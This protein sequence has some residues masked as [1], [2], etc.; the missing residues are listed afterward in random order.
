LIE[1]SEVA[2]LIENSAVILAGGLGSRLRTVLSDRP[3]VLAPV[4]GRHFLSYLLDQ[5][6][7]AGFQDV[8]LCTGYL[9][10]QVREVF[11]S[12]FRRLELQYSEE[13]E[14]RGT[15]GALR[16]ALRLLHGDSVLVLNGDSYCQTDLAAFFKWHQEKHSDASLVL[17]HVPDVS[18]FGSVEFDG[19]HRIQRFVEKSK[20]GSGWINA[21]IYAIS[22]NLIADIPDQAQVSLEH[23]CFPAW[24]E[25]G[26]FAYPAATDNAGRFL[27]IGTP[28]T[29]QAAQEFFAPAFS[30]LNSRGPR[31]ALLDRDG[32]LIVERNY[33]RNPS[34][35]ELF[36]G[37][38]D[39]LRKLR[40]LGLRLV[41][42]S[43]QS[44]IARGFFDEQKLCQIH[45]RLRALLG[46]ADV[47]LDAIYYCPHLPEQDCA[48]R[49]PQP[50][51]VERAAR[52]LG[53]D[54]HDSFVVGDKACDMELGTRVGATTVLVRTGYGQETL[55]AGVSADYTVQDL[56]E[57]AAEIARHVNLD[58][59]ATVR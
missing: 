11:G 13:S 23:D 1:S 25:I 36:P 44:G 40:S 4:A 51:M 19:D 6:A 56:S 22:K 33:L 20:S 17:A 59:K 37:A 45:E 12:R 49:K 43:N 35:V 38:P 50:G 48:C 34:E 18:R 10:E 8:V 53:L 31:C 2:E 5:L 30:R 28:A 15:G 41:L 54:P 26:M 14:P 52:D 16:N 24:T 47:A 29:L 46:D 27:D 58:A 39:A 3:K 32:T 57:A 21:G 42:V 7:D 55:S 9:G